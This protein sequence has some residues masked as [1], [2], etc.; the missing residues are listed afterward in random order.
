MGEHIWLFL[1]GPELEEREE[2]LGIWKKLADIDRSCPV[3]AGV[4]VWLSSLVTAEVSVR[5]LCHRW[6]DHCPFGYSVSQREEYG[7]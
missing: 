2:W 5:V 6:S 1:V 7:L 3:T 4:V